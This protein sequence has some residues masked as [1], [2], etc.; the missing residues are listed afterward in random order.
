VEV[1]HRPREIGASQYTLRALV[2]HALTMVT[3]VS[4]AA[5]RIPARSAL[6]WP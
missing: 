4:P 6:C 2:R 1:D 3:I 5:A